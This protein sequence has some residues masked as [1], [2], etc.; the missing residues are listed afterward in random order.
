MGV[1]KAR[2][3]GDD[4]FKSNELYLLTSI[5]KAFKIF[6][7]DQKHECK[8]YKKRPKNQRQ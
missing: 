3:G 8:K 7:N 4:F 2:G 6:K 1:R 5:F